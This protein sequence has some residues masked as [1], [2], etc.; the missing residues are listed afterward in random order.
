MALH[1][2]FKLADDVATEEQEEYL[3]LLLPWR[4]NLAPMKLPL[5]YKP[6]VD[7]LRDNL[8]SAS[9]MEDAF[10]AVASA[11]ELVQ[12]YFFVQAMKKEGFLCE[13]ISSDGLALLEMIPAPF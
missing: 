6:A 13:R 12:A 10:T 1:S 3:F 4:F 2:T 5:S 11:D 9:E 8:V 7:A